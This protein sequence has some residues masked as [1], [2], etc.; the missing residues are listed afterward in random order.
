MDFTWNGAAASSKG[1]IVTALP[2]IQTAGKRDETHMIP[3][4]S[5]RLHIQDG[6][7]EEIVKAVS[8]Y[9]PYEQGGA[10]T[11][12]KTLRAW[13]TGSGTVLFSNEPGREYRA[14]IVS[15]ISWGEWVNGY[16]DRTAQI[17]F[18]CE[19]FAYHTGASD[20][21]LTA[22]GAVSNPGTAEARPLIAVTGSGDITLMTGGEIITLTGLSGTVY[23]D[24]AAEECYAL[25]NGA[26]VSKNA[27]MSGEFPSLSP[28]V[29]QIAWT[30]TVTKLLI[31]PRWRDI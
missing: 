26:R 7:Y 21:T 13:L 5:G 4:R 28:G 1:V 9:L 23:L 15:E 10:V 27:M 18:E 14:R 2:P 17:L 30:G 31:T 12:L 19:P 25:S 24:S 6:A 3:Y 11:A 8:V 20:I 22:A 29:N 16:E